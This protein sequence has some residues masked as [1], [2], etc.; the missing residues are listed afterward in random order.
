M[1]DVNK[2]MELAKYRFSL[3]EE[4]SLYNEK[5][6]DLIYLEDAPINVR[7]NIFCGIFYLATDEDGTAYSFTADPEV[8]E[9]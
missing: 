1:N 8:I 7:K 3:A 6:V 2:D 5:K 4:T 9:L